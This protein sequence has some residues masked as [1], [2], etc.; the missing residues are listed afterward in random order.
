MELKVLED[1]IVLSRIAKNTDRRTDVLL[2]KAL[3]QL[4]CIPL[5]LTYLHGAAL[6]NNNGSDTTCTVVARFSCTALVWLVSTRHGTARQDPANS[7]N[8]QILALLRIT[9]LVNLVGR[10][11]FHCRVVGD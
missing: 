9:I 8:Y 11:R 6:R 4:P 1:Y 5:A 7:N 3:K 2:N 10:A